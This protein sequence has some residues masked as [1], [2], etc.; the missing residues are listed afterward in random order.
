[1]KNGNQQVPK[2]PT[3]TPNVVAAFCSRLKMEMFCLLRLSKRERE[4]RTPQLRQVCV[5]V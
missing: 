3:I 5:G 2:T 1:M 4:Q